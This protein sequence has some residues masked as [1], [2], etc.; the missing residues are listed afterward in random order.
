MWWRF[1]ILPRWTYVG[2]QLICR[3]WLLS[4]IR[5][6]ISGW[7]NQGF[8]QKGICRVT[9]NEWRFTFVEDDSDLWTLGCVKVQSDGCGSPSSN[10]QS[11]I[12]LPWRAIKKQSA[13]SEQPRTAQ[14][15]TSL[16]AFSSFSTRSSVHSLTIS[17]TQTQQELPHLSARP[18]SLPQLFVIKKTTVVIVVLSLTTIQSHCSGC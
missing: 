6:V 13:A 2:V 1:L 9:R 15:L 7:I 18:I 5:C 11:Y 16:C 3:F 17:H 14:N 4:G 12:F 10:S 8:F